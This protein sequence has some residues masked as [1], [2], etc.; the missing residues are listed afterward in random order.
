MVRYWPC[1]GLNIG[2]ILIRLGPSLDEVLAL[3]HDLEQSLIYAR[4]DLVLDSVKIIFLSKHRVSRER[5]I[6]HIDQQLLKKRRLSVKLAEVSSSSRT[7]SSGV[8]Q[9]SVQTVPHLHCE[10]SCVFEVKMCFLNFH[11]TIF[12][13]PLYSSARWMLSLHHLRNNNTRFQH[14]LGSAIIQPVWL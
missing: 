5:T 12:V 1:D 4:L 3:L 8:P 2:E 6:I 14:I 9:G 7:V 11:L 10:S 13:D